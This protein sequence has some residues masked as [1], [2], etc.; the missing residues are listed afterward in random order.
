MEDFIEEL[1][2]HELSLTV[3]GKDLILKG[4]HGKLTPDEIQKVKKHHHIVSF[5]KDNKQSLVDFLSR[6][7]AKLDRKNIEAMYGLSPVQEGILFHSSYLYHAGA[8]ANTTYHTQFDI[9]FSSEINTDEFKKAWQYVINKHTILRTGFIY[10]KVNI[11]IQ[12]VNKEVE[13]PI[14]FQDFSSLSKEEQISKFEELKKK[15]R[16]TEFSFSKP[17]LMR[18]S[19]V[20][21]GESRFKMIWTKHHALWDGW[22]GQII[23][24]ELISTYKELLKGNQ[25]N[26]GKEDR[27][28]DFINYLKTVDTIKEKGF[29]TDYLKGFDK[30]TLLPFCG[31]S[32]ERNKGKGEYK[33][34]TTNFSKDFTERLTDFAKDTRITPNTLM[35]GVWGYILGKYT[36]QQDVVYGSTV[37]GRPAES[38]YKNKVGLYINTIPLRLTIEEKDTVE[39]FLQRLQRSSVSA[40]E[41]QHTSLSNISQWNEVKGDIFDSLLSFTNYP[42]A[43]T[44][45]SD[46]SLLAID[47][48]EIKENNNYLLSIQPS[49]R[50]A[51][52][53]DF[54]FN[55]N[56]LDEQYVEMISKHF[57]TV[58]EQLVSDKDQPLSAVSLHTAEEK[59]Q[60][61]SSLDFTSVAFNKSQN[62]VAKFEEQVDKYPKAVALSLEGSSVSYAE[63]NA[64][65]NRIANALRE[66]GVKRNDLVGICVGRSTQMLAGLLGILKAGGAYVPIDPEYPA[67]RINYILNDTKLS[68][69]LTDGNKLDS[70]LVTDNVEILNL[71]QI[72]SLGEY[73]IENLNL[74]IDGADLAYVIFTSGTTG[75]PKGVLISH[76]NVYRLFF[77][78]KPL[79]DFDNRDVW[80]LFHSYCFDFSVWEIFGALLFGGKLVIVPTEATVD[81]ALFASLLEKEKVTILN[82]TPSAFAQLQE[83]VINGDYSLSAR[84]LIFGG[85]G[86]KP[87]RVSH[88]YTKFPD[89]KIINMYGITETT[90]HVTYKHID[91][92][93]IE[94]NLSNIGVPI[95]TMGCYLLD[96]T[97]KPIATGTTGELYVLGAGLAKGYL[98]RAELTVE[99]FIEDP[100][101]PGAYLYKTGDLARR[102]PNGDLEYVGRNDKQV[103]IRGFRIELGEVEAA[104]DKCPVLDQHVLIVGE[105]KYYNTELIC[106]VIPAAG[107]TKDDVGAYLAN[108]LPKHMVPTTLIEIDEVPLT[109]NGKV[110]KA[111][112]KNKTEQVVD[113]TYVAARNENEEKIVA[114]WKEILTRDRI[115]VTDDFFEF[116]GHSLKLTRL[117]TRYNKDFG[118]KLNLKDL[119]IN[120]TVEQHCA[121]LFKSEEATF[122]PIVPAPTQENYPLSSA[123]QRMWIVSQI[124]EN[125]VS[126]SIPTTVTLEGKSD[127][128]IL[129]KAILAVVERHE[130][131]RTNFVKDGAE[132][133]QIIRPTGNFGFSVQEKDFSN[134]A[135]PREAAVAYAKEDSRKPFDLENDPLIR[136]ILF[137]VGNS[138][139]IFYYNLHHIIS[140]GVSSDILK[141][142]VL[143]YYEAFLRNE[144]PELPELTIQYKDYAVWQ[145]KQLKSG[146]Y[147]ADENYWKNKL[148]GNLP[149]LDLPE[150]KPRP[151]VKTS[152]GATISAVLTE[153]LTLKL[154][155]FCKKHEGTMFIGVTALWNILF[156]K[157][158]GQSD[159]IMGS[160]IAGRDHADLENQIG[161]FFN[162][163]VLKNNVQ[164]ES[165]FSEV[166]SMTKESVLEDVHHQM[167]PFDQLLDALDMKGDTSRNPLFDV[168]ISYHNT[169][170]APEDVEWNEEQVNKVIVVP[171]TGA[172]LDML[173]NIH[174][175]GQ[176]L[177]F[178]INY[179]TDLYETSTMQRL[180]ADFKSLV[181]QLLTKPE[182]AIKNLDFKKEVKESLR[183]ANAGKF[184]LKRK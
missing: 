21:F 158:T 98:N 46:A 138:D 48:V 24:H 64:Q 177:Y 149:R 140:D 111:A 166:F 104:L 126:Y 76:E 109:A 70:S 154:K 29:W 47:E 148:K 45:E 27:Y 60:L 142:D 26:L 174:E 102:L 93:D 59:E 151:K 25:P 67:E 7:N 105:D 91:L 155:D 17:P 95:P 122:K 147:A 152:N 71:H 19:L 162:T 14:V 108:S 4:K 143:A 80:S 141:R 135:N 43:D 73:G 183:A 53:V 153:D 56:V 82:Q 75:N 63:L 127:T 97:L 118:V 157:Y 130:T 22:S 163:L 99:R 92:Q 171:D 81:T 85:E 83:E 117:I 51:L 69:L 9:G 100:Y 124:D 169:G 121:L 137:R 103:K 57:T 88:W 182:E 180:V 119:F 42:T 110:D 12:F 20:K 176:Y 87:K 129:K 107:Q 2:R 13:P 156:A 18:V 38:E 3:S 36:G 52:V 175:I 136:A 133:R 164:E 139:Y 44:F 11:S 179:N 132:V 114:I 170:D 50:Q 10:D 173:I 178:D 161:M 131:L 123:Q 58:L 167:Y 49:I 5:I 62:L 94:D 23:I 115:G 54:T 165:T 32:H 168:M 34:I 55:S 78:E 134:E 116:G 6:D 106:Y 128:S 172:K 30:P 8:T 16:Y 146:A 77:N 145:V 159:I 101:K 72:S 113:V 79:F 37:S 35:Q 184:N 84:Y 125:S 112:L 33:R 150:Q 61:L 41:F 96:A 74:E 120:K 68:L 65:A 15:D 1:R 160:P 31:A 40:R 66:K 28:E 89:C 90:V 39:S 181:G 144:Q 86:L